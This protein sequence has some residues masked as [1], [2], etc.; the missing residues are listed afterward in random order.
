MKSLIHSLL[1]FFFKII[2]N[3]TDHFLFK[4]TRIAFHKTYKSFG[5][6]LFYENKTESYILHRNET[7]SNSIF[8]DNEFDFYKIKRVLKI[9]KK[10]YYLLDI[11]ANIGSISL[12]AIKRDYFKKAICFEPDKASYRLLKANILIND[13]E[14]QMIAYNLAISDKKGTQKLLSDNKN[15]R[16]NNMLVRNDTKMSKNITLVETDILDN[17]CK[18]LNKENALIKI[19]VQGH[20]GE[21]LKK[22]KKT[23]TKKIP[24]MLEFEPVTM[25]KNW[26]NDYKYIFMYYNFFYNINDLKL[27]KNKLTVNAIN[28]LYNSLLKSRKYTDLLFI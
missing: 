2:S 16:G 3:N 20:E 21:I 8:I 1:K 12:P 14:D 5:K 24:I 25:K 28:D 13:I 6:H 17:F 9:I 23:L 4:S 15:N 22:A 10:K 27:K 7:I 11:G 18:K 19:D 26:I